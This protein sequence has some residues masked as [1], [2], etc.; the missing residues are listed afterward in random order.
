MTREDLNQYTIDWE[1]AELLSDDLWKELRAAG[2]QYDNTLH[3]SSQ[4]ID[5][6]PGLMCPYLMGSQSQTLLTDSQFNIATASA[7]QAISAST[8][9]TLQSRLSLSLLPSQPSLYDIQAMPFT[10]TGL[11]ASQSLNIQHS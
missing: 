8:V 4:G 10:E 6:M 9:S 3:P 5:V 7:S 11:L 1:Y 2:L